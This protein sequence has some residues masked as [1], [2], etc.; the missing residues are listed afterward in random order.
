VPVKRQ[1]RPGSSRDA[2]LLKEHFATL[3][4]EAFLRG[5]QVI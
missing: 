2:K 3:R 1:L 4:V 5:S